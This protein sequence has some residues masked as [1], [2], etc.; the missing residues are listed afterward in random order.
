MYNLQ[1]FYRFV[2]YLVSLPATHKVW[3]ICHNFL[4]VISPEVSRLISL[5]PN[6][7]GIFFEALLPTLFYIILPIVRHY[8]Y[9]YRFA[10]FIRYNDAG[11]GDIPL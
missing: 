1:F 2:V 8:I 6:V 9:T 7:S 10:L 11:E 4:T 5:V 3:R